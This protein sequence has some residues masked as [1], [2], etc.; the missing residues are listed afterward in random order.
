MIKLRTFLAPAVVALLAL[1]ACSPEG[2]V[3]ES[4]LNEGAVQEHGN[5]AKEMESNLSVSERAEGQP[6]TEAGTAAASREENAKPKVQAP[7]KSWPEAPVD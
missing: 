2:P 5:V 1:V 6:V 4:P 7:A 3:S